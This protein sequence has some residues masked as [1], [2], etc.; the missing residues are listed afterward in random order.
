MS[1]PRRRSI[2]Y[3]APG[4]ALVASAGPTRN[5][6]NLARALSQWADVTVTFQR[7]VEAEIPNGVR[8]VE[9]E[10]KARAKAALGDDAAV[11][12]VGYAEFVSY[13]QALRRF[14]AQQL[15]SYD[16][17][18]EKSWLLSGYLSSVCRRRGVL[19]VPVENVVPNPGH[20]ARRNLA[21]FARLHVGRWLA[22]HYLRRAPLVIAETEFLKADIATH[23]RVAPE[24]IEVV[25]LGV[26]RHLFRPRDQADARLSLGIGS[27]KTV[28]MYVGVLDDIHDLGPLLEAMEAEPD[29]TLEL[30]LVG[31]GHYRSI[32]QAKAEAAK[33]VVFHG[34]VAHG[35]VPEFIAAAD[36]CLAPYDPRVFAAGRL[37][38]STMK[39]PEYL[40]C[41]RPV[42]SVPS[43]R[44]P[45]LVQEGVSGFLFPNDVPS[46]RRFLAER[47]SRQRLRRMGE[48]AAQVRLNSW[49]DTARAYLALC[50]RQLTCSA[51]ART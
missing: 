29:P 22:G 40:S 12:G 27:D 17:V 41:G 11:R 48:A 16:I 43:G 32:H 42:A 49:E 9:I 21:K 13:L 18:L 28:L 7:V 24:R 34:R 36:L 8:I 46:W 39:I 30:H 3:V 44:I 23:W 15:P 37:G 25:D 14:A 31:D 35:R 45:S 1:G 4:Q 6:L 51:A 50:E 19:G 20:S 33:N 38:Y 47:P 10:P 5:V 2:C 26:D